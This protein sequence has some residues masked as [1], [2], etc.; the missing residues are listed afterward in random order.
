MLALLCVGGMC[1]RVVWEGCAGGLCGRDV[2]EGCAGGM[3]GRDVQE[4]GSVGGVSME[5]ECEKRVLGGLIV[6]ILWK[7]CME[8]SYVWVVCGL[9]NCVGRGYGRNVWDI[10]NSDTRRQCYQRVIYDQLPACKLLVAM[11]TVVHAIR[12]S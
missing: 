1:R 10:L 2:Q 4:P 3:C 8:E 12:G 9:T 5:E 7:G 11:I 6:W